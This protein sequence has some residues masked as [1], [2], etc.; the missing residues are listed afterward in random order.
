MGVG[1][2]PLPEILGEVLPDVRLCIAEFVRAVDD[3]ALGVC[4]LGRG[5]VR[6]SN[7]SLLV[8][9]EGSLLIVV[10]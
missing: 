8:T 2:P 10:D 9:H 6:I 4:V 7:K 5:T 1:G 3:T